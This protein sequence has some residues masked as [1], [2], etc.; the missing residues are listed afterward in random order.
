MNRCTVIALLGLLAAALARGDP[1]DPSAA[2]P[3]P[4]DGAPPTPVLV[5]LYTSEGCS[6]CPP[7]DRLLTDLESEQPVSGAYVVALGEHVDYWDHLGWP[8][9]FSSPAFTT[10][11]TESQR[12]AFG[13]DTI[14]TPQIVVDGVIEAVGGDSAAVRSAIAQA[15][16]RPKGE[17]HVTADPASAGTARVAIDIDLQAVSHHAAADVLLAVVEDGLA[18]DVRGG[19]NR[20]RRLRHAAVVRR[21]SVIGTLEAKDVTRR[22]TTEV[23]LGTDWRADRL[24]VVAF[25]QERT[26]RAIRG[27]GTTGIGRPAPLTFETHTRAL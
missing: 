15:A 9:R 23:A 4:P 18:T 11:Q 16:Q 2:A 14:Y 26:S 1:R 13:S 5:E 7:A 19:E 22:L 6:S 24:R 21:L 8:D 27:V 17:V 20:G 12:R 25:V 10:R 3:R